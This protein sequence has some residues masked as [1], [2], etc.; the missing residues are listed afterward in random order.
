MTTMTCA[1]VRGCLNAL[2]DNELDAMTSA[3]VSDHLAA[4]AECQAAY[5]ALREVVT[6]VREEARY[7]DLPEGL[8]E[9]VFPVA[10]A[11]GERSPT[12]KKIVRY[13][14]PV[15]SLAALAAALMVY[16]A[17]PNAIQR[18]FSDEIVSSHVRSL[19]EN[20]LLDVAS[21]DHH[22]VKPWFTGKLDFSP[23]VTDFAADGFP[24]LGG[25]ID[26]VDHANAAV[27]AY[28]H[29]KHVVNVFIYPAHPGSLADGTSSAR[30]YNLVRWSE[31]ALSFVAVS[32]MDPVELQR[33]KALVERQ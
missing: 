14:P 6:A 28:G 15:A 23:P 31:A 9:R 32:D 5:A 24:L 7:F 26:Y 25:R 22:T 12:I 13:L 29:G 27:L 11:A 3:S 8:S 30:G 17:T 19:Q 10:T 16:L 18:S 4:C 21:S 1:E 33:F 20:H 2:V